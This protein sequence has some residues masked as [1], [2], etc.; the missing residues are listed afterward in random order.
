MKVKSKLLPRQ[1]TTIFLRNRTNLQCVRYRQEEYSRYL[2]HSG[3]WFLASFLQAWR[4]L[5][6][7]SWYPDQEVAV[8]PPCLRQSS[9]P[10][11]RHQWFWFCRHPCPERIKWSQVIETLLQSPAVFGI[12]VLC[13]ETPPLSPNISSSHPSP[14]QSSWN[15]MNL[16]VIWMYM[17]LYFTLLGSVTTLS[18]LEA[19]SHSKKSLT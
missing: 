9:W 5:P 15:W 16:L 14:P 7:V 10:P 8:F 12:D 17:Y 6:P 1:L 2:C 3:S 18:I 19:T 13:R 4:R 11:T